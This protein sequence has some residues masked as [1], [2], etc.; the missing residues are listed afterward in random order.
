MLTPSDMSHFEMN[1]ERLGED[2]EQMR[3]SFRQLMREVRRKIAFDL[4]DRRISVQY[5]PSRGGGCEMF[6]SS[7]LPGEDRR[8]ALTAAPQAGLPAQVKARAY[9]RESV[10]RMREL[11]DLLK[12]CLRLRAMNFSG[13]SS[14]YRDDRGGYLL[15]L[16]LVTSS[17]L[18]LPDEIAFL[19]EY[20]DLCNPT[21]AKVYIHEHASLI[22]THAVDQLSALA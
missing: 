13:E 20:G 10:Y 14:A 18:T 5:F 7:T 11:G 19:T 15:F 9:R 17:P 12:A 21:Q 1:A 6:V 8:R 22:S 4:D 16:A 3:R 2:S